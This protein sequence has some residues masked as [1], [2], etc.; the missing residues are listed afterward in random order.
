MLCFI[1]CSFSLVLNCLLVYWKPRSLLYRIQDKGDRGYQYISKEFRQKIVKAGMT[2]S[3]SRV[4][5]CI[6][7]GPMEGFWGVM[8]REMYYGR[9]CKTKD[10][11]I[12]SIE[13]YMNYYT[14][15]RVQRNLVSW[16]RWNTMTWN[17]WKRHKNCPAKYRAE[18]L[19]LFFQLSTWRDAYQFPGFSGIWPS[20]VEGRFSREKRSS[21]TY[22]RKCAEGWVGHLDVIGLSGRF[23]CFLC[24]KQQPEAL[25]CRVKAPSPVP[26]GIQSEDL[27]E[28][29][30]VV[31]SG[32]HM[33]YVEFLCTTDC[34]K[35]CVTLGRN[36]RARYR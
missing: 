21:R 4:A 2:Q 18:K 8:K 33:I 17:Y 25:L 12:Q 29:G 32:N 23:N 5:H 34:A 7:N 36:G 3:M 28:V 26:S 19:F 27:A 14:I 31:N 24:G 6:D 13:G 22:L 1:W 15:K 35:D 16:R 20:A 10:E 30:R 9:K 11:L